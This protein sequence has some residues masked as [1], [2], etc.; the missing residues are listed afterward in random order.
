MV[1]SYMRKG[2]S[3]FRRRSYTFK[4]HTGQW[5]RSLY[6]ILFDHM[7]NCPGSFNRSVLVVN[8]EVRRHLGEDLAD[9]VGQYIF[10]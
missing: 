9:V 6:F 1:D 8:K 7:A 5:T 3:F 2:S 4:L 10:G